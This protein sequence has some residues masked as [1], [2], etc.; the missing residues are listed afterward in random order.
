[1]NNNKKKEFKSISSEKNIFE[2]ENLF[3]LNSKNN[4]NTKKNE[5]AKNINLNKENELVNFSTERKRGNL[6]L[7]SIINNY[8]KKNLEN[9][10][11]YAYINYK[12][13]LVNSGLIHTPSNKKEIII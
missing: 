5:Y 12:N 13:N 10:S 8:E 9:K 2:C 4:F 6:F 11:N 3:E 1:M 7:S